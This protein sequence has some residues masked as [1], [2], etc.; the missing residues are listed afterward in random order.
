MHWQHL[1][2]I[3]HMGMHSNPT[4]PLV[5]LPCDS[6]VIFRLYYALGMNGMSTAGCPTVTGWIVVHIG[7]CIFAVIYC[8]YGIFGCCMLYVLLCR[9]CIFRGPYIFSAQP[10]KICSVWRLLK[11]LCVPSQQH[12]LLCATPSLMHTCTCQLKHTYA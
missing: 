8:V 3:K 9:N 5:L 4:L 6:V 11:P 2:H 12:P 1:A 7:C 10:H